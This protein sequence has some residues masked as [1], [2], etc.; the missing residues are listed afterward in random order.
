[1]FAHLGRVLHVSQA[2]L[3]LLRD[4][5]EAAGDGHRRARQLERRQEFVRRFKRTA[6][7]QY[8]HER[9]TSGEDVDMPT[10][11]D[12]MDTTMSKRQWEL[13][14]C[15]WRN[16]IARLHELLTAESMYTVHTTDI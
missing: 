14:C 2:F 10:T 1:M 15:Q 6:A 13:A 11:P 4:M 7:Y 9:H 16:D 5:R 12:A 8:L 3:S